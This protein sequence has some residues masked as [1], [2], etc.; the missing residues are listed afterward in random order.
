MAIDEV[1]TSLESAIKGNEPF[2]ALPILDDI[3]VVSA[4]A[5]TNS[6]T[7]KSPMQTKNDPLP[8]SSIAFDVRDKLGCLLQEIQ[9]VGLLGKPQP[10][11][12]YG[13]SSHC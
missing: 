12:I 10:P 6:K 7:I 9:R 2:L 13:S 1:L 11:W 3:L 5:R 8:G 4:L